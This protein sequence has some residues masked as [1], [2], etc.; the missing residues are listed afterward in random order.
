MFAE[1]FSAQ[2][3]FISTP[4]ILHFQRLWL[5]SNC[6]K[7]EWLDQIEDVLY[8][9]LYAEIDFKILNGHYLQA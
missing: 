3:N 5:C 8:F 7:R 6:L 1:M 2:K 4:T 9:P